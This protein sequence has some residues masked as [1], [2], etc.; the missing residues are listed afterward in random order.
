[1][2]K[3]IFEV[4]PDNPMLTT[5]QVAMMLGCSRRTV[6][7]FESQG[8]RSETKLDGSLKRFYLKEVR[9]F[10]RIKFFRSTVKTETKKPNGVT[11]NAGKQGVKKSA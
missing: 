2:E 7:R 1:M 6:G 4:G 5:K 10:I 11:K 9:R 8:L 3:N